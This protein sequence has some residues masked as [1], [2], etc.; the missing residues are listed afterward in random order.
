MALFGKKAK[1]SGC[2][3]CTLTNVVS[4]VLLF[5]S[6]LASAIGVY[7]AHVLAAGAT[8][9]TSNGSLSLIAF[10]LSLTL[11]TKSMKACCGCSC[12]MPSKK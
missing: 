12:D 9:G 4:T 8:F 3:G 10:A 6:A 11:L 7:K 2:S 5:I 1:N